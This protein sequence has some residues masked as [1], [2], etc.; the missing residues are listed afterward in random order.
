MLDCDLGEVAHHV[1]IL[2]EANALVLT[3]SIVGRGAIEYFYA[4]AVEADGGFGLVLIATQSRE[5][6]D[7]FGASI[8]E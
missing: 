1:A 8:R 7:G 5:R 4:S 3:D 6:S 2:W